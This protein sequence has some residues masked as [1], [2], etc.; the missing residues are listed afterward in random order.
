MDVT[1]QAG[2]QEKV[3][4][5]KSESPICIGMVS[6]A[7]PSATDLGMRTRPKIES[8]PFLG[9]D[10][11]SLSRCQAGQQREAARAA[12]V[13]HQLG[14]RT[15]GETSLRATIG[16]EVGSLKIEHRH[17]DGEEFEQQIDLVSLERHFGGRT[18]FFLC[19]KT[20]NRA[21]KLY[22]WPEHGRFCH[23]LAS[24]VPP[25]YASQRVGGA[26]RVMHSIWA[27]RGKLDAEGGLLSS[28]E[29]PDGMSQKQFIAYTRRYLM[30]AS[31]LDFTNE[32]FRLRR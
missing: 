24:S 5:E 30:L 32:G 20:G 12:K 31:R 18:W 7:K 15:V 10:S 13:L 26:N 1:L 25:T 6:C 17:S 23:R 14:G 21:R 11:L 9:T 8:V 16:P 22:L 4:Q 2:D 3:S 27:I 28:F 19:P 29:K